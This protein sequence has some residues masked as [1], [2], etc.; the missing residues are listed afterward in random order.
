MMAVRFQEGAS[1]YLTCSPL[2][3]PVR[4]SV[5]AII[6]ARLRA[7]QAYPPPSQARHTR[8][9]PGRRTTRPPG[10]RAAVYRARGP[11]GH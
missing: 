10:G 11:H 1:F 5:G 7:A 8:R 6:A 9:R 2:P 3:A 4:T